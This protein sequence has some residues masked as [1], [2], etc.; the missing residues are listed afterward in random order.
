MERRHTEPPWVEG[1]ELTFLS[2]FGER[3]G[4][5]AV[6]RRS[7]PKGPAGEGKAGG[8]GLNFRPPARGG[9]VAAAPLGTA[10]KVQ[11]EPGSRVR[12]E[13]VRR[14]PPPRPQSPSWLVQPQTMEAQC[15]HSHFPLQGPVAGPHPTPRPAPRRQPRV[16]WQCGA[17]HNLLPTPGSCVLL[18]PIPP[19]PARP[20]TPDPDAAPPPPSQAGE[21]G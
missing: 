19:L 16:R 6:A 8:S 4:P 1:P 18:G 13:K 14:P 12:G 17:P 2:S 20:T 11:L 7:L 10:G 21:G 5:A 15:F 9:H 3:R